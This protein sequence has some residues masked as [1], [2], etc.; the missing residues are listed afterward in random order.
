MHD[1]QNPPCIIRLAPNS[2]SIPIKITYVNV[3]ETEFL[4]DHQ[5]ELVGTPLQVNF[6]SEVS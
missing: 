2:S 6:H 4:L 3:V 5:E 1:D